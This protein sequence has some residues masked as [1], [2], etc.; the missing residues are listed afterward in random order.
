M[1]KAIIL[2]SMFGIISSWAQLPKEIKENYELSWSEE[3]NGTDADLD[4]RWNSQNS[5]SGG[6]YVLCSRWR[7]N[8]E[9]HDGI[10]ELKA[11]KESRGGQDW[12][13]GNIWTKEDFGY[14]YFEAK[15]KYAGATGTNNSFWMWPKNRVPEG[16][17]A[18]ELD[19]NE[20][21]YPNKVNTNIH[22]WTD[23]D[24]HGHHEDNPIPFFFGSK[25]PK[26]SYSHVL[27]NPIQTKKV[28]ISSRHG[29]KI[30]IGEIFVYAPTEKGYPKN[31]R[32]PQDADNYSELVNHAAKKNVKVD[33]SGK[34][35][36][37][38]ERNTDARNVVD[39][40][41][42]GA[43]N[44]WISQIKGEKW[45]TL[46]FKKAVDIG[47]IQF[48]NAWT[49]DTETWYNL[50]TN[51]KIEYLK[52]KEWIELAHFDTEEGDDFSKD[53]HTYGFL[54][55]P[56]EFKFYFDGKLIREED[57]EL[58]HAKTNILLSL[59]ILKARIG[60]EVTDA[61]DGTSMKVDY[62]RY[63]QKKED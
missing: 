1:K 6:A 17:K 44:E 46:K 13:C 45:I 49:K 50:I 31:P 21:H 58:C 2:I 62:V 53:Y 41:V 59:A 26:D 29:K 8:A 15:Y 39:G 54:W 56:T 7:E 43:D 9:V 4:Q 33:A 61:I 55:T 27:E 32:P 28:R 23:K 24:E 10:L 47:C 34:Y 12:T 3:F 57:N 36:F 25:I 14:G 37:K 19:V 20:G 52:Y 11:K 18:F 63:F 35:V 51:Y 30:N 22:N 16:E 38:G 40:V 42:R 60:G 5:K 48:T